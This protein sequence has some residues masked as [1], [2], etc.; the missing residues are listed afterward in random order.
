MAAATAAA[1]PPIKSPADERN[2]RCVTLPNGLRA[3]LISDRHAD[4]AAAALCVK[5]GH[6]ADPWH[7]PG[8]AH[9]CEHM[10][11]LGSKTHPDEAEYK[12]YVKK[13]GGTT[14]A[15]TFAERTMYFFTLNQQQLRG[16]APLR[17]KA[18]HQPT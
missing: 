14:N 11:F 1:A 3:L 5:V 6:T 18:I 2:Y 17:P 8:L 15:T 4:K 9:F 12:R 7:L 16:G 10:C 13:S